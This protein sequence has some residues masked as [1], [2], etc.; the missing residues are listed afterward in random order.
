MN[1]NSVEK[2]N[3]KDVVEISTTFDSALFLHSD[4]TV[5]VVG[6]NVGGESDVVSD[7]KTHFI[8]L[9]TLKIVGIDGVKSIS[10]SPHVELYLMDD[11]TVK[12]RGAALLGIFGIVLGKEIYTP[13]TIPGLS[14]VDQIASN[15]HHFMFLMNDCTV[16]CCGFNTFNKMGLGKKGRNKNI[17]E[18]T[19]NPYLK[20]VKKIA[21]GRDFTVFLLNDGTVKSCGLG[22]FG[23]LGFDNDFTIDVP[24]IVESLG[25]NVKD[26]ACG[27]DHTIFLLNDGTVRV[28][29]NNTYGQLGIE[30]PKNISNVFLTKIDSLVDIEK[31]STGYCNSAFINKR[32]DVF[33]CGRNRSGLISYECY[34]TNVYTPVENKLFKNA[35]DVKFM[36]DTTFVLI[37]DGSVISTGYCGIT[38]YGEKNYG[39]I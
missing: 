39:V 31:I 11:G 22:I 1:F 21:C 30:S 34:G 16:K 17:F 13:T 28:C 12:M 36:S 7:G 29:G 37:D 23:Q 18:I 9:R 3:L 32:G 33:L 10:L 24:K 27:P 14:G 19:K 15:K 5:S 20:N 38:N 8:N 2:L 35:K 25:N 4:G 6:R 26:V